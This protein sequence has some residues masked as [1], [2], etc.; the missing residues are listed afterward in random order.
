VGV[1][2]MA[3]IVHSTELKQ[4]TASEWRVGVGYLVKEFEDQQEIERSKRMSQMDSDPGRS[5]AFKN[6]FIDWIFGKRKFSY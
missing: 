4:Y 2:E 1:L 5:N 6:Q 3:G